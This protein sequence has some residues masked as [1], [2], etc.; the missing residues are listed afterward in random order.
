MNE[1]ASDTAKKVR[2]VL[3]FWLPGTKFSVN[4]STYSG[5]SSISVEYTDGPRFELV[6]SLV[7]QLT[8]AGFDG[9]Q[10]FKTYHKYQWN[11][12]AFS[13]AD[14]I[15]VSRNVSNKIKEAKME[16]ICKRF[17]IEYDKENAQSLRIGNEYVAEFASRELRIE[18]F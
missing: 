11:G 15:F 2:Q 13:G 18:N 16:E 5:G 7:S 10:D 1:K 6:K 14:Y 12:Q 8:S 9:I 17:G 3:K 4:T